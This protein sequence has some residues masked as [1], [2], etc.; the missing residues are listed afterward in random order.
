[1]TRFALAALFA[2]TAL[3]AVPAFAQDRAPAHRPT[4][5]N[6]GVNVRIDDLD[7]SSVNGAARFDERVERRARNACVGRPTLAG[8]QC[9]E[10]LS[11]DL[12]DALPAPQREDYARARSG[13]VLAMVP[14]VSA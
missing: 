4:S 9:R 1:M 3:A 12:R 5:G 2:C 13:R 8:L 11:R 10:A 7:L 6:G 14:T